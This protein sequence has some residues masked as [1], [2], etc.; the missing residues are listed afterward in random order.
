MLKHPEISSVQSEVLDIYLKY[1]FT[2]GY[3]HALREIADLTLRDIGEHLNGN[4]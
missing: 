4:S 1:A 3:E 2:L